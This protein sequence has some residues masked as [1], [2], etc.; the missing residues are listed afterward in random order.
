MKHLIA[1]CEEKSFEN[2]IFNSSKVQ[3]INLEN[4]LNDQFSKGYIVTEF[5]LK[6]TPLNIN[7]FLGLPA[8]FDVKMGNTAILDAY[9]KR[10][11]LAIPI[12]TKSI[13]SFSFPKREDGAVLILGAKYVDIDRENPR[14][15]K[16]E[17]WKGVTFYYVDTD[18]FIQEDES[19]KIEGT[20]IVTASI[21]NKRLDIFPKLPAYYLLEIGTSLMNKGGELE[22]ILNVKQV[23]DFDLKTI[24][25]VDKT[26]G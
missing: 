21:Q 25:G 7:H 15:K 17:K 20:P 13:K 9:K 26:S 6:K 22:E 10:K 14:T 2:S 3:T 4:Q 11:R 23:G 5:D 8:L 24:I 19:T 16:R 12:E 18:L 1:Y